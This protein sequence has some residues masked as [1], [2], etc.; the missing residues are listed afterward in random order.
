M[1]VDGLLKAKREEI[2]RIAAKYGAR[3]VRVFGSVARGEA[4]PASDVDFLVELEEGRNLLDLVDLLRDLED[5]LA[6]KV[7]VST[8]RSLHS[9]VRDRILAD[10]VDLERF[11]SHESSMFRENGHYAAPVKDD[12]LYLVCM[13]ESCERIR[14]W[15]QDGHNAFLESELT[16]E[17]TYYRL[18]MIGRLARRLSES[19]KREHEDIPWD[20]I[21]SFEAMAG[22][23]NPF[24]PG[25]VWEIVERDLPDLK[26]KILEE[27]EVQSR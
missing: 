4:G 1:A 21:M 5:L 25:E 14:S 7:D 12:R 6:R 10:A 11:G 22:L 23:N 17:A 13:L 15:T 9:F 3:N 18:G 8:D 26:R 24:G 19:L 20:H 16:R 2:L 27:L